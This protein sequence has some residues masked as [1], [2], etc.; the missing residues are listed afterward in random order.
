MF[1]NIQHSPFSMHC[2]ASLKQSLRNS[3]T[4]NIGHQNVRACAF[5]S[6]VLSKWTHDFMENVWENCLNIFFSYGTKAYYIFSDLVLKYIS[7]KVSYSYNHFQHS[8]M[9][10]D[11][12]RLGAVFLLGGYN[13]K[14]STESGGYNFCNFK[15]LGGTVLGFML[16]CSPVTLMIIPK[17]KYVKQISQRK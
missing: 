8:S 15:I 6:I 5:W 2:R 3:I 10:R 12:R 7:V 1:L 14:K 9:L 16:L 4:R 11:R 17:R 13:L